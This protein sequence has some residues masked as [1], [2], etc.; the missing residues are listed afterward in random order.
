MEDRGLTSSAS[1]ESWYSRRREFSALLNS[2]HGINAY[3]I[4]EIWSL[5]EPEVKM[6]RMLLI[7]SGL[8]QVVA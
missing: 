5:T 7:V 1:L 8:N 4:C 2:L 6:T 3:N